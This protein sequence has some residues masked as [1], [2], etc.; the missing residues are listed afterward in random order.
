MVPNIYFSNLLQILRVHASLL[1]TS[2]T[3]MIR[4]R[5]LSILALNCDD[6]LTVYKHIGDC[7]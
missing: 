4:D 7:Q 1:A 2:S 6:W 3:T 5:N